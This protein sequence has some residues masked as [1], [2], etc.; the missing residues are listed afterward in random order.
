MPTTA[1]AERARGAPARPPAA[2]G[3]LHFSIKANPMPALV[4]HM[5]GLVDGLDVAPAAS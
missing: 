1:P 3:A 5:A 2:C 4:Q